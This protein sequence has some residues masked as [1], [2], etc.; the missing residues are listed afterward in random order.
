M[1]IT[2]SILG[3]TLA[4]LGAFSL[5]AVALIPHLGVALLYQPDRWRNLLVFVGVLLALGGMT[6]KPSTLS[7]ILLLAA[8]LFTA[9][10]FFF[11]SQHF[12]RSLDAPLHLDIASS[13]LRPGDPVLGAVI[14]G[15]PLAWPVRLLVARLVINDGMEFASI[16]AVW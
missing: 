11:R 7:T 5:L 4:F 1:G 2:F 9:A 6:L 16:L 3:A 8:L 10:R 14:E 13:G 15:V 12:I